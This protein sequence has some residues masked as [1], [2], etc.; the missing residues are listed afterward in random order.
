[1]MR[2]NQLRTPNR[3]RPTLGEIQRLLT[4]PQA[5]RNRSIRPPDRRHRLR[6]QQKRLQRRRP[7]QFSIRCTPS[8]VSMLGISI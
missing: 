8:E 5:L 1:M 4:P 2:Q 6:L 7:R 3:P